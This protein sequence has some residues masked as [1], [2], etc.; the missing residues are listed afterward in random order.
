M[1][2]GKKQLLTLI[3]LC[4]LLAAMVCAY[5]FVPKSEED[6]EE[7]EVQTTNTV[8]VVNI[9]QDKVSEIQINSPLTKFR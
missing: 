1:S 7:E 5:I 2:K 3:G 4:L 9:D 8:E 6:S